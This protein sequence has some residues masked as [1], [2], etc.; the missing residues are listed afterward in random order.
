MA[1]SYLLTSIIVFLGLPI[2][3]ILAYIAK[4]E[5]KPGKSYLVFFQSLLF[6]LI[7]V[8]LMY[9]F[10]LHIA[11]IIIIALLLIGLMYV[12]RYKYETTAIYPLLA[13]FL[14]M[15][16]KNTNLFMIESSLIFLYGLPTG[17][18]LINFKKNNY[19][20]II[21]AHTTFLLV[22]LIIFAISK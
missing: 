10:N 2:G 12:L 1:L 20:K 8:F 14:Y 5:I 18:L 6:L 9:S 17:S 15:S 13:V 11:V 4:E 3:I 19:I 22:A 16:S 7:V 21:L